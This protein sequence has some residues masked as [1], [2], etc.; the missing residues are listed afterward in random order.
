[1]KII[2]VHTFGIL[3]DRCGF[4]YISDLKIKNYRNFTDFQ[5]ELKQFTTI[6]GENN[7]GKTNLLNALGLIF[8]NEIIFFKRRKLE[9]DDI[10]YSAIYEFKKSI[11]DLSTSIEHIEYPEVKIEAT[12]KSFSD[13]QQAIVAEW[14]VDQK[15][16]VSKLTYV[17]AN[18]N[19]KKNEWLKK[20]RES[21]DKLKKKESESDD[22]FLQ[23][24]I[25][26]IDFP[27]KD[28]SYII[29]GGLDESKPADGYFLKML[30]MECLDALR[31]AKSELV[32]SG[33]YRLLYK[34][35]NNRDGDKFADLK[36]ELK[37]LDQKIRDNA[38]LNIIKGEIEDYLD[39]ISL[40]DNPDNNRVDFQFSSIETSELLKKI[41]LIYGN[42]PLN[43]E[44]NG[45]GRNNLLYISLILSHLYTKSSDIDNVYF[46]L[47]GIEEPEAHLH[48]NLQEH[49]GNNFQAEIDE[50]KQ[51]IVTSHSTH[52]VNKLD[53]DNIVILYRDDIGEIQNHY[54]L[55]NF[56]D[57]AKNKKTINYLKKY[58]DA[59]NSK[60][61]FSRKIIL[62]EGIAEQLLIPVFFRKLYD[63]TIEKV[64]CNV[65]NVNGLAF[66]NYLEVVKNGYFVKC[67]VL[68]DS[69]IGTKIENRADDLR[70]QYSDCP[71]IHIESTE[72]STFEKDI[73]EFNLT[74]PGRKI[75]LKTITE[76]RPKL[77][78]KYVE[79]LGSSDIETNSFFKEI[80]KYKSEFAYNLTQVLSDN[81]EVEFNVPTY[82][83]SSFR[84]LIGGQ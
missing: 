42:A 28:Y 16:T 38:E 5:I 19:P 40:Q 83:Q 33:D 37:S 26:I 82:I 80:E 47:I 74:D 66:K 72:K 30:R 62:V 1:M 46:R 11:A 73:I 31:D 59:T 57:T 69:D 9:I 14:F 7:S 75:L 77:G 18:R 49:L 67:I 78:K 20:Q 13:D 70:E 71:F 81:L 35:L 36:G 60:L 15:F 44:R 55:S 43:V 39:K 53:L 29:Y 8:S 50:N 17:F 54:V 45:M 64:G 68:T 65:V 41:S 22:K 48:P 58:L 21:L 79:K 61:F 6:I 24:K 63:K 51:I 10:N 2:C 76:T 3:E 32:A 84:F 52:I 4:M 23:H 56:R 34:I 25:D 27:I 12:M